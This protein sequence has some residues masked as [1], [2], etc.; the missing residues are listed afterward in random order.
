MLP[1]KEVAI[2]DKNSE[3][4]GVPPIELMENAGKGLADVIYDRFPDKKVLFICGTGNNGGDAYV[5]AR[6]LS[7]KIGS[8]NVTVFLIK[9]EGRIRSDISRKN[10]E[11]LGCEIV[12]ELDWNKYENHLLVD[13]LLGTG[14]SGEIREPYRSVMK[15][16]NE[17][18]NPI[19]SVDVPSGL[20]ADLKV[21]P[22]ITV[23]FHDVKIGMTEDKCG[24]IIIKDIG[25]PK[26]ALEY[27]GPGEM[28]LYPKPREDSHKGDNGNLLIV[29]GGPY[30]GAPALAA[31]AAYRT[32]AD[33]VHLA[34]PSDIKDIVAGY[35]ES[36]IVHHLEGNRLKKSHKETVLEIAKKCDAAVLGPGLGD[37]ENTLKAV[38][39]LIENLDI[40]VLID[41]DGLKAVSRYDIKFENES[42]ITPHMGEF[43]R[44]CDEDDFPES[45]ARFAEKHD[46]T[47]VVKGKEDFITDGMRKKWNDFGNSAMTVGGTGD[48]LSGVIG[49][50]ISKGVKSYEAGRLGCYITCKAGD[51]AFKSK[52]WGL[53]PEDIAEN[54]P[55]ILEG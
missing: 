34:V 37:D 51:R 7:D 39:L 54:I 45:A 4:R 21:N 53:L 41:A 11:R 27:T 25:I 16:M 52:K 10:F 26:K 38:K 9:G 36:F 20:G 28:L 1:F 15:E 22:Q 31:K 42:I 32:G 12:E 35:S 43:M 47:V 18:D 46:V 17:H 14:I 55:E 48:T 2:A 6:Y 8:Q 49:A 5:A 33:L 40:P 29:G 13:A 19:V 30:T 44:L 23:T 24:E 3:Y 50:L